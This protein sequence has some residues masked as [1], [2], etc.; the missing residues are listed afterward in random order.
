MYMYLE[1]LCVKFYDTLK[2]MIP[3]VCDLQGASQDLPITKTYPKQK[4]KM[5]PEK[6]RR[7][8]MKSQDIPK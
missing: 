2:N 8:Q 3:G 5:Y 7:T 4:V 1:Q 6:S